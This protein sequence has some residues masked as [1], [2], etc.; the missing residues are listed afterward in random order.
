MNTHVTTPWGQS[1]SETVI[2]AGIMEYT[3]ASHGGIHISGEVFERMPAELRAIG[4]WAGPLWYEEDCDSSIVICAF[5]EL[6]P[7]RRVWAAVSQAL[8]DSQTFA[9]LR[10][11]LRSLGG[12]QVCQIAAEWEN[13]NRHRY[14]RGCL[15]TGGHRWWG[16]A[17]SVDGL[18][19]IEFKIGKELFDLPYPF[20]LEE[21]AAHGGTQ[22]ASFN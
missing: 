17:T 4:T 22:K 19:K 14:T 1:H 20:S 13:E 15:M 7:A 2:G 8:I 10:A 11:W 12:M 18:N 16:I 6:F 9:Q 3:T 21:L 5:P